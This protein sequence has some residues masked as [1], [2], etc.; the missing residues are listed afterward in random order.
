MPSQTG[1]SFRMTYS[2]ERQYLPVPDGIL[3]HHTR[4]SHSPY[5][6]VPICKMN[7]YHNDLKP[8]NQGPIFAS[9]HLGRALRLHCF[10]LYS[11][12]PRDR[13]LYIKRAPSITSVAYQK[14]TNEFVVQMSWDL[15]NEVIQSFAFGF[16]FQCIPLTR[17]ELSTHFAIRLV[18]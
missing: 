1:K 4:I 8:A 13:P 10:L 18:Q 6:W 2:K 5:T 16:Y 3:S 12:G 15:E 17:P 11:Q 7:K 9:H 14:S